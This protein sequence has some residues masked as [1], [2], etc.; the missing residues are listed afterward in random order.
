MPCR[1]QNAKEGSKLTH[2]EPLPCARHFHVLSRHQLELSLFFLR[3]EMVQ[4]MAQG[5]KHEGALLTSESKFLSYTFS[6]RPCSLPGLLPQGPPA[7]HS[8]LPALQNSPESWPTSPV[9]S[10]SGKFSLAQNLMNCL[11]VFKTG[12]VPSWRTVSYGI[13]CVPFSFGTVSL[14]LPPVD[15]R[16][17]EGRSCFLLIF[18]FP[19]PGLL[20]SSLEALEKVFFKNE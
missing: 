15:R 11:T 7:G 2:S 19:Q 4:H 10:F 6:S 1:S 16:L 20:P 12:Q 9:K 8:S 3:G 5:G 17:L 13:R 18:V 14:S